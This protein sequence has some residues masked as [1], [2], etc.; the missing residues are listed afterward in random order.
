[1]NIRRDLQKLA[2]YLKLKRELLVFMINVFF[3]AEFVK[4]ENGLMSGNTNI[5]PHSLEDTNSYQAYLQK[6][7]AQKSLIY[8]KSTDLQKWI[9][10]YL[11]ENN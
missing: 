4:I 8:S 3:E 1:V 6:M 5:T 11:D 10:K 9:L 7:K 2:D